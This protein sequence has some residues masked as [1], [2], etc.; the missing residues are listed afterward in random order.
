M[1][2]RLSRLLPIILN[3][4]YPSCNKLEVQTVTQELL[5]TAL[6]ENSGYFHFSGHGY[7]VPDNPRKSA[8]VLAKSE[9]LTLGDIV[10]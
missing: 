8:L 4:I 9:K 2:A 3:T 1:E 7:H 6:Q 10:G 5:T